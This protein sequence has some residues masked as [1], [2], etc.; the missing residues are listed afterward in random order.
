MHIIE[1]RDTCISL[2]G[3]IH[4]SRGS[5][6]HAFLVVG[7]GFFPGVIRAIRANSGRYPG[8]IRA[9]SGRSGQIV[10]ALSGRRPGVL[11]A[12]SGQCRPGVV[13]AIRANV[14]AVVRALSGRYPGA[15]R[16]L[17]RRCQGDVLPGPPPLWEERH[18]S[19]EGMPDATSPA[20]T[21]GVSAEGT[22]TACR[23]SGSSVMGIRGQ[24][25]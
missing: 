11:R 1:W 3:G 25:S 17:S 4:A 20:H 18:H 23:P 8:I 15:I 24:A 21:P 7:F 2:N 6:G 14:R 5:Q 9:L 12:L 16:A 22:S 13:R 10:R 19:A